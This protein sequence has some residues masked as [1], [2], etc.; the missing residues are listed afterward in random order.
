MTSIEGAA[1]SE[2]FGIIITL[3]SLYGEYVV[4]FFLPDGVFLPCD[5][6][7]DLDISLRYNSINQK[8]TESLR[9]KLLIRT[10]N[11]RRTNERVS[12]WFWGFCLQKR[13]NVNDLLNTVLS[14][15]HQQSTTYMLC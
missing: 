4:R 8:N 5:H 1:F 15:P 7:L 6:G 2:L 3:F 10:Y 14:V 11:R 13:E 9:L 12:A